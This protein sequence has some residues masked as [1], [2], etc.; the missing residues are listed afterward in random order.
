MH[1]IQRENKK[2]SPTEGE[3]V[4]CI[5]QEDVLQKI[6]QHDLPATSVVWHGLYLTVDVLQSPS[7][8]KF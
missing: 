3:K 2:G 6:W 1:V 5:S 7:D 4:N 8:N